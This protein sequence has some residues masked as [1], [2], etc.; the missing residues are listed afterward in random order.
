M[1]ETNYQTAKAA[2]NNY[3]KVSHELGSMIVAQK[4]EADKIAEEAQKAE[5][6]QVEML[7]KIDSRNLK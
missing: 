7:Y 3:A 5:D 2:K 1:N 4:M 6:D